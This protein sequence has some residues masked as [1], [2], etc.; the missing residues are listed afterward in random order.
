MT[1]SIRELTSRTAVEAAI[2]EFD[3][4]GRDAFLAKYG[5][6]R[7]RQYRLVHETREY[8]SKAIAGVAFGEQFGKRFNADL[9][10]T[11][12]M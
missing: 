11:K 1:K 12:P 8:D 2:A 9:V 7:A 3:A 5:F 4:L 10:P 6:E